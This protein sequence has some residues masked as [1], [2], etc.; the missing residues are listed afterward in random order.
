MEKPQDSQ[1]GTPGASAVQWTTAAFLALVA[2]VIAG[3]LMTGGDQISGE[4]NPARQAGYLL[5]F[6]MLLASTIR[7][8]GL[9]RAL[10]MSLPVNLLLLY[11]WISLGWAINPGVGL[12]RIGLTTI[13]I[14]S[15]FIAAETLGAERTL[16][17][18]KACL[19]IVL[20][21]NLAI[22]ALAPHIGIHQFEVGGDPGLVGDWRGFF[23]EKNLTGAVTAATLLILFFDPRRKSDLVHLGLI[24]GAVLLLV[25]TGSRTALGLCLMAGLAGLAYRRYDWRLWPFAMALLALLALGTVLLV[26]AS[27]DLITPLLDRQD[28]FTGRTQIWAALLAYAQENWAAGAGYGS[29]WNIGADSP[30]YAYA[31]P[32]AWLTKITSAHN[33]YLD[34][35]VQIGAPGMMLA[36]FALVAHPLGRLL[37]DPGPRDRGAL[38][39]ALLVLCA[40]QNLTESTMLD[41]DNFVQF[42]LMWTI[43]AI[44]Q[45]R[46]QGA[47][48]AS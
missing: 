1:I 22:V 3:P 15:I 21:M 42:C 5:I 9:G 11:C 38:L 47:G 8:D 40:G 30:I 48:R 32:G 2:L 34:I 33:G 37:T 24:A 12:R 35:I 18:L 20:L 44:C 16:R 17:I 28:A 23:P 10:R 6:G 29:F 27:W 43:A 31:K 45:S 41:R 39:L 7:E 36:V 13:I 26:V 14:Y 25:Q 19:S 4:G 46:S